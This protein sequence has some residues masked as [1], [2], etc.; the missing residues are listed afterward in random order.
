M[1]DPYVSIGAPPGEGGFHAVFAAR[2]RHWPFRDLADF[3]WVD[4][5]DE[6]KIQ[7][8]IL[9]RQLRFL[10]ALHPG[11]AALAQGRRPT[12]DI[13]YLRRPETDG[14]ECVL[15]GKAFD[16]A[17][18]E[19]ARAAALDLWRTAS[20]VVPIGYDLVPA[21]T[22]ADFEAWSGQAL[23]R[24]AAADRQWV[25]VRRPAEFL[26]WTDE[27][28]PQQYL[29]L[30]YPFQWEP[31]SWEVVWAALARLEAP[32]LV[33]V[34]L[35]PEVVSE[36]DERV[37][38]N[39]VYDLSALGGDDGARPPLR[40]R[41]AE[42]AAWYDGYLRG[43][44]TAFGLR[45]SVLGA[46]PLRWAVR[47]ALSGPGWSLEAGAASGHPLQAEIAEPASAVEW[48]TALANM[49]YLEQAV[50]GPNPWG[51]ARLLP[52][53]ERLRYLADPAS[54]L[55]AFRLPLLPPSGLPGVSIGEEIEPRRRGGP[56]ALS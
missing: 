38:S 21:E 8:Q 33:S 50:W 2:V 4:R 15:L 43:L 14:T 12:V 51:A 47:S 34:S 37:L 24:Q 18:A 40:T 5:D 56:T 6:F 49:L 26:A 42:A 10:M 44:R 17:D 45:V 31:S 22:S 52:I 25:E 53:L 32:A 19:A 9:D 3:V 55:C 41:A 7:G 28:R 29:P 11:E 35:R 36:A 39:L 30:V 48:A 27:A 54:A 46:P 13:R 23:I 1:T 16:P 20:T